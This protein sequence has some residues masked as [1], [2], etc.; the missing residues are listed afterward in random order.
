MLRKLY[1]VN[2]CAVVALGLLHVAFTP[3]NYDGF[4]LDAMWFAGAGL[5]IVFAG[6]LNLALLRDGGRLTQILCIVADLTVAALFGAAL[7]LLREPQVFLGLLLF[8]LETLGALLHG[9]RVERQGQ[10]AS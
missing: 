8:A 6:F 7:P 5:A 9:R 10:T 2:T 1:L 4:G 3:C